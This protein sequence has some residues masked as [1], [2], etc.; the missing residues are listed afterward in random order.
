MQTRVDLVH[1]ALKNLGVLPQ[2]QTPSAEEYNQVNALVEP[3]I[4]DL[5]GRDVITLA[6]TAVFEDKHFL[7]LAHV[8]A[9]HAQSEFGMQND[10]ALTARAIKGELD[11]Q[12]IAAVR[13]T[14]NPLEI[15]SF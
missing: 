5:A 6:S 11:L 10:Q 12:R 8:L 9:G 3:M 14:Y 2:G 1:K 13:P 15:Q 4:E 7:S